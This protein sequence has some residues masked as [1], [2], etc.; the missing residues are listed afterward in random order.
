MVDVCADD[1]GWAGADGTLPLR[2][3]RKLE[4]AGDASSIRVKSVRRVFSAINSSFF[5]LRSSASAAL[6]AISPSSW[7]IYSS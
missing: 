1:D 6:A 7:P 5:A 3:L 2:S 4:N